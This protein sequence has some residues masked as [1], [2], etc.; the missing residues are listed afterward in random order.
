MDHAVNNPQLLAVLGEHIEQG[1]W[2]KATMGFD[3]EG[4]SASCTFSVI[5]SLGTANLHLQV[6]KFE[7]K[8][9]WLST[10][11]LGITGGRWEVLTLDALVPRVITHGRK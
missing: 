1:P 10:Y 8:R 2:Y 7:E 11:A 6:V 4:H 5:G 3:H 9:N